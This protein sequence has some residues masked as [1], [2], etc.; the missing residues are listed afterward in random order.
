MK[1]AEVPGNL[2][3]FPL[4]EAGNGWEAFCA[5]LCHLVGKFF[6]GVLVRTGAGTVCHHLCR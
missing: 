5:I 2:S 6:G 1:E 4:E 3:S